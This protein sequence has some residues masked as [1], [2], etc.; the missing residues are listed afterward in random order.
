MVNRPWAQGWLW[1]PL[2]LGCLFEPWKYNL[3]SV[4][5]A[6]GPLYS[7]GEVKN[8]LQVVLPSGSPDVPM[9]GK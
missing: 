4:C 6:S 2:L 5:K 9:R 3:G 1:R 7:N 8:E